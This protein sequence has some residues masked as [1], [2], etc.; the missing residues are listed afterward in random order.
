MI[1]GCRSALAFVHV[2]CWSEDG[3]TAV[4]AD[5]RLPGRQIIGYIHAIDS[6]PAAGFGGAQPPYQTGPLSPTHSFEEPEKQAS[7]IG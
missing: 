6:S 3:G 1:P 4:P 7:S 2:N 5:D